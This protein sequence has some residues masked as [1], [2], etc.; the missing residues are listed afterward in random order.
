MSF[1]SGREEQYLILVFQ[2]RNG[3]EQG[4]GWTLESSVDKLLLLIIKYS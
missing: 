2:A 3:R 4:T 1:A